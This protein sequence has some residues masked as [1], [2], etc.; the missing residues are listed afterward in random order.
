MLSNL[1]TSRSPQEIPKVQDK[2]KL[3]LLLGLTFGFLVTLLPAS[4]SAD[5][6]E[7][8]RSELRQLVA[9]REIQD[10][11]TIIGVATAAYGGQPLEIRGFV[12]DGRVIYRVLVQGADGAVIEALVDGAGGYMVSHKTPMGLAISAEARAEESVATPTPVAGTA[13]RLADDRNHP[14]AR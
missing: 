8:N 11:E 3:P 1:L 13:R 2:R 10:A 7:L 4:S 14:W 5:V 12:A 6:I 9:D